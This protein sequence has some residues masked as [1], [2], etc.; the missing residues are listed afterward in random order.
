MAPGRTQPWLEEARGAGLGSRG[1]GKLAFGGDDLGGRR[2]V[3]LRAEGVGALRAPEL[4]LEGLGAQGSTGVGGARKESSL[5][6][7]Q[8]EL[9]GSNGGWVEE[10]G[11]GKRI[12]DGKEEGVGVKG[13][14]VEVGRGGG[15]KEEVK[16]RRKERVK[17]LDLG[18]DKKEEGCNLRGFWG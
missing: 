17:N 11:G 2:R 12:G 15:R 18:W 4:R 10:E 5:V 9:E 7:N 13:R 16:D 6:A 1:H 3:W 14:V 8:E